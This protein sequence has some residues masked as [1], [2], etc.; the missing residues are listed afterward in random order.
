MLVAVD[1][2]GLRFNR[3]LVLEGPSLGDSESESGALIYG[4]SC[5]EG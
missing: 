4:A 1:V 3:G 2:E 5:V